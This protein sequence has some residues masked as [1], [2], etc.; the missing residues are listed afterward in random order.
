MFLKEKF[1]PSGKFDKVKSRYVAGGHMQHRDEYTSAETSSPTVGL[2]SIFCV[3]SIAAKERR[4][5]GS[6]DVG[7]AYL[8]ATMEKEVI[9]RIESELAAMLVT[10]YPEDYQ[11][12]Q[13]GCIYVVLVKALYGCVESAKL[14]YDEITPTLR[15]LGFVSNSKDLCV[16]NLQ[17]NG[18]QVTVCLYVDDLLVTSI[19][20]GDIDWLHQQLEL[21]YVNVSINKGHSHSYLG[22]T[23][24]FST[25]SEVKVN[26]ESY[27]RDVLD[28]YNVTG[29]RLTP[30]DIDLYVIDET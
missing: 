18:H 6:M 10:M 12:D 9:M 2:Q 22:M 3:I 5:V 27:V 16:F 30:A 26:M 23:L 14:W 20:E 19:D 1:K 8:N 4:K 21:N 17:R 15:A 28:L 13:D 7:T 24:N 29:Y 11:L 25:E